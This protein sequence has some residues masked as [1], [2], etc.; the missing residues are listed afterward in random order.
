[1]LVRQPH[2]DVWRLTGASDF[3]L[4]LA[5]CPLRYVLCDDVVRTCTAL[6]YSEGDELCGCLDLLHLPAE[7]LWIEWDE[8]AR[9]E[10]LSCALP[11]YSAVDRC[12]IERAGALIR[13]RPGTRAGSLR[14]FWLTRAEPQEPQL[15]AVETL[16]DFTG[17]GSGAAPEA[18]LAGE[19]VA[20]HDSLS[21]P[22][23]SLLQCARFRLDP[24]W[25]RYYQCVADHAAARMEVIR[26][27]L[28]AV[29]SDVPMLLALLLLMAVRADLTLRPVDRRRLNAKRAR[30][31][32]PALLE[33]IEVS[34]PLLAPRRV[35]AAASS[36]TA[37]HGPRLHHVRGHIVRRRNAVFWR[38]PHWRGHLRL[39]SVRS[40]TVELHLPR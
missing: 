4:R 36:V 40:R 35:S 15:A 9:R 2:G 32:R 39:G 13:A 23:E 7:E 34:A 14:T 21:E 5:F 28:A 30:L 29:A 16:L 38:S 25:L 12:A 17:A 26:H 24:A 10:A 11:E 18:L 8:R 6:A 22:L 3:A 1:L 20:V 37:R 31:G 33:H 27:S 19:A